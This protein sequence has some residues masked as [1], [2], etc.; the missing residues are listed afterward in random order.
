[1][2]TII[3]K[4]DRSTI[5]KNPDAGNTQS[6]ILREIIY[7]FNFLGSKKPRWMKE[8]DG[9]FLES[10][11]QISGKSISAGTG[12]ILKGRIT[13]EELF[14][15][16]LHLI[17]KKDYKKIGGELTLSAEHKYDT[18]NHAPSPEYLYDYE[19]TFIK[20]SNCKKEIEVN[21]VV[22]DYI[23]D[24]VCVE[25][26]PKCHEYNTF[27]KYVYEKISEVVKS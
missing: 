27:P 19:K 2:K 7:L 20:C 3:V 6:H 23:D 21:H 12:L 5:R 25:I 22:V 16:L 10:G 18:I 26:C 11:E 17:E 15:K 24:E 14:R 4:I 8:K 9:V 1:M 13:N